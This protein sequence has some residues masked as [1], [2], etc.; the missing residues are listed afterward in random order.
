MAST[1]VL[2]SKLSSMMLEAA[3]GFLIVRIGLC[4]VSDT[5]IL[6]RLVV[7]VFTPCLIINA[8]QIDVTPE[9]LTGFIAS[10]LLS[11][12]YFPIAILVTKILQKP[13]HLDAIDRATI[14]YPNVGN[15]ILPLVSMVLGDEMV[16]YASA[17]QIPFN[18]FVWTHGASMIEDSNRINLKKAFLN[19]NVISVVIGL[20]FL[21]TGFRTPD[22]ITTAITGFGS[23]VGPL[24]M[25]V[26]GM[27]IAD[28]KLTDIFTCRRAY[29][30]ILLRLLG[31]PCV[32]LLILYLTGIPQRHASLVPVLQVAFMGI[33]APPA[34][35]ISQLAI[36][37]D[38]QPL[39]ASICNMLGIIFCIVTIPLII[40]VYGTIFA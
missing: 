33:A 23:M 26:I 19:T 13:L 27:Q 37:H 35:T 34:A 38:N 12:L 4:R 10:V 17:M 31:L 7:D 2:I 36:L 39:K 11:T 21:L 15:L 1:L 18:L 25:L 40:S 3:I 28:S 30:V 20:I 22:I 9:R 5:K 29:P 16:F 32:M 8:F 24:S 6:S 14:I